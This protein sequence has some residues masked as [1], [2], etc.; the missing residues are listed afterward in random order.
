MSVATDSSASNARNNFRGQACLRKSI[1]FFAQCTQ[2]LTADVTADV[3][4]V[5]LCGS[6][7]AVG[8]HAFLFSK[9]VLPISCG[10]PWEI[11]FFR[12]YVG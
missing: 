6:R 4:S 5:A 8:W 12:G 3:T 10:E 1:Q 9:G 11:V 2:S 7:S